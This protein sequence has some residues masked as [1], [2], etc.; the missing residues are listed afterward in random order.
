MRYKQFIIG[1]LSVLAVSCSFHEWEVAETDSSDVFYASI[2]NAG[3]PDTRVYATE[4]LYLRWHADDRVSIFN[5]STDNREYR[6]M[7]A[8]GDNAGSFTRVDGGDSGADGTLDG[9]YAVYPYLAST[10][11]DAA[12][13]T[14]RRP[15]LHA[16]ALSCGTAMAASAARG[17]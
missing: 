9:I 8:T 11:I 6:F 10:R 5:N 16:V 15:S 3:A 14:G 1:L 2:E 7:G 12:G 17:S 13:V 4:D